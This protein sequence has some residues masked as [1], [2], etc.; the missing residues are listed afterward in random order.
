[1]VCY[2]GVGRREKPIGVPQDTVF[3]GKKFV[4]GSKKNDNDGEESGDPRRP[5]ADEGQFE[6]SQVSS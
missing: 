2:E 6:A 4:V 1:V 5:F 3:T